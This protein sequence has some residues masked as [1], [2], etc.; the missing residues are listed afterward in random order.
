MIDQTE[1]DPSLLFTPE[2]VRDIY[3]KECREFNSVCRMIQNEMW[4]YGF[5]DIKTPSFEFFD[6]FDQKR[7]TV[8]SK[9]MFKFFDQHN[10]TL[11]L[12]PDHT[13]Q[14]AR[15]VSRYYADEDMQL[16]LCYTGSSFIH[17]S[18]YQGKLSEMT[19]IGAEIIGDASSD[20]DGE[21]ISLAI[22][23]MKKSGLTDFKVD[24][25]HA[26]ILRG[27]VR[28]AG[29]TKDEAL[30][31]REFIENKNSHAVSELLAD[32]KLSSG[33]REVL[34]KLPEIFADDDSLGFI[35]ERVTDE[36]TLSGIE[37]LQTIKDILSG[38]NL[39]SYVNF[40]PGMLGKMDYY[41]G[42]IFKAFTYGTGEAILSGGRYD[43]LMEQ[44]GKVAPAVGV[45]FM[46]DALMDALH[47]ER[48]DVSIPE[49]DV[50]ILYRSAN[51]KHAI[52]LASGL[53]A[54]G[55]AAFLMRKNAEISLDEYK[56]YGKRRHLKEI[57][58]IDDTG[59]ET[60]FEL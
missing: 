14:I 39:L 21:M 52:E 54:K 47:T 41:T 46:I 29:L 24:I 58:Y 57:L 8:G 45:V 35:K 11:V 55:K 23:C 38:F 13:P 18:G 16:R 10:N 37:R 25:G 6:I 1:F 9:E 3:G 27:L 4:L 33:L 49:G 22:E 44:F 2:G 34:I 56:E 28:E 19:Q 43:S 48:V 51:R 60:V 50:L 40:D 12:R 36:L 53:R 42:V 31:L 15:C 17:R 5:H 59:E 30:R 7:G 20:A 32:H 26:G